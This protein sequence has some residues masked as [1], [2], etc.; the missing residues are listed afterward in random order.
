M[1]EN[2]ES[3]LPFGNVFQLGYVARDLEAA[4]PMMATRFGFRKF[5]VARNRNG[6][7]L[8]I[9]Q[10]WIGTTLVEVL[11][12]SDPQG[13]LYGWALPDDPTAV[14][15]HHY[16]NAYADPVKWQ[17]LRAALKHHNVQVTA[18]GTVPDYL[19]FIYADTRHSLGHMMEYFLLTPKARADFESYPRN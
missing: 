1:T 19:D 6:N 2:P 14:R 5:H 11:Q 8:H 17:K 7:A 4:L 18:E 3:I 9:A 13:A 10:A 15:L 12:P 16:A